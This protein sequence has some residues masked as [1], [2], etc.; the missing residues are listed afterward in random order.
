MPCSTEEIIQKLNISLSMWAALTSSGP[1]LTI[2]ALKRPWSLDSRQQNWSTENLKWQ[3]E[4]FTTTTA[5][6]DQLISSLWMAQCFLA[7]LRH[8][9]WPTDYN[10]CKLAAAAAAV[11]ICC[12]AHWL[13]T[14][15]QM[16]QSAAMWV[17]KTEGKKLHFSDR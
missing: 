1:M 2:V 16:P 8:Q 13:V 14:T 4:H 6:C 5:K 11:T 9:R 12:M 15:L 3:Q 7:M 17:E 10:Y